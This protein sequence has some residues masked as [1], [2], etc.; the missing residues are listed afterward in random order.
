VIAAAVLQTGRRVEDSQYV[1]AF[2]GL[3]DGLVSPD[4]G[5][6]VF[7]GARRTGREAGSA[8]GRGRALLVAG[9]W[10]MSA[11]SS[12]ALADST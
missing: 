9:G 6:A 4:D 7:G 3:S 11:L 1:G 2:R 8:A 5:A 12:S 10:A